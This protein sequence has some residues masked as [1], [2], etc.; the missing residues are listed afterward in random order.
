VYK[1]VLVDLSVKSLFFLGYGLLA[2]GVTKWIKYNESRREELSLQANTDELTGLLNRR[3]F[4]NYIKFEF[5]N[6]QRS[7][8]IFSLIIIDID[9][10]KRVNDQHGHLEGD[11][12][13]KQLAE[14]LKSGFRR[15]DKVSRWGGEEF[16]ILLPDTQLKNA[17]T[18]AEKLRTKVEKNPFELSN[19]QL[20]LTISA[21]VSESL[22]SDKDID[23]IIKRA[24]EALYLAKNKRNSVRSLRQ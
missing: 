21:G 23:D 8:T 11:E 12:V 3:S 14:I 18:V 20:Q 22:T 5:Y 2:I 7:V 17:I 16:A 9:H 1:K 6:A 19:S 15:S 4:T 13:L 10:F 24:D